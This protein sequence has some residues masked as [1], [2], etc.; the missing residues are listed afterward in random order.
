MITSATTSTTTDPSGWEDP[1][2]WWPLAS[3][4]V[5]RARAPRPMAV[6]LHGLPWALA[7]MGGDIRALQDLCPH[8]RVPLSAGTVTESPAGQVLEC[9]Y[10]G[11]SFGPDGSCARIPAL[12][13]KS[14]PRGMRS[15][16]TLHVAE[17]A[18]LVWG[19]VTP[20]SSPPPLA[21]AGTQVFGSR[22]LAAH[23]SVIASELRGTDRP[24]PELLWLEDSLGV[25]LCAVSATTCEL[26]AVG[27]HGAHGA[28]LE[29]ATGLERTHSPATKGN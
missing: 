17:R 11:W 1:R 22:T 25:A 4:Q 5:V 20:E 29:L 7:S 23:A 28:W 10:H 16:N 27:E 8:R 6:R 19:A 3:A 9:G 21:R 18:G 12:G 13:E 24:W 14:V 15:V 2:S 26:F